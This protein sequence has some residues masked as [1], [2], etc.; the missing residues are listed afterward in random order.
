MQRRTLLLG[1]VGL[2][3]AG[4]ASVPTAPFGT[5]G[6]ITLVSAFQGRT[7][8]RGHFRVWLTGDERRF[9]A[10]LNGT[11]TGANGSRTLTVVEDFLYDDGQEDRLTWVFR[12]QGPGRWTGRREDTVGEA[13]VVEKDGQIRLSYTADFKSPSG[14]NRL[15]FEDILYTAPNGDIVNDAIVTRAGIAVASVRF[16]IRR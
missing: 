3:L 8:G 11:V 4:C 12:E 5:S 2:P 9:T 7:T 1:L 14:V 6:P 16:V 15:G 13:T 10:R